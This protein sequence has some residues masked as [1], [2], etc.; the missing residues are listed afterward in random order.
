MATIDKDRLKELASDP[1]QTSESIARELGVSNLY[2]EFQKDPSLKPIYE[3]ARAAARDA[4]GSKSGRRV[5]QTI[6]APKKGVS[7]STPPRNGNAKGGVSRDLLRKLIL[8]FN[9]MDVYGRPSEHFAEIREE[10]G[11][12]L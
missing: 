10:M 5:K 6:R 4:G 8:E 2:Y 3:E 7:N 9:H 12:L 11:S 1:A